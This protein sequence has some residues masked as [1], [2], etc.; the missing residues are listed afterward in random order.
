MIESVAILGGTG[1]EGRGLAR[2]W[3]AGGIRVIIGSRE[4]QRARMAAEEIADRLSGRAAQI[5]GMDN[6]AAVAAS[7]VVVLAVPFDAQI[8][9]LKA[10][11]SSFRPDSI[12]I[13]T[14]VPLAAAVGD[15]AT[16]LLGV[17]QGSAAE[18]AAEFLPERVKIA[19]GFHNISAVLLDSDNDVDCDALICSNDAVAR[20]VA[21]D[22]A[23]AIP[24]VR[25]VDAGALENSRIVE[26]LT[27]LLIAVNIRNKVKHCG[28]RITG[29]QPRS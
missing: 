13:S 27:A 16:R 14:V 29:L 8:S 22:L 1:G 24:G 26:Q 19:A 3:A 21:V 7:D 18:Q 9:I 23:T 20:A 10:V 11:K 17:W 4:A 28:L 5:A 12:V 15:R 25:A 6:V 2:R